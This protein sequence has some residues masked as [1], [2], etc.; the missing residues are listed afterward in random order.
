MY[1]MHALPSTYLGVFLLCQMAG[2]F[3]V[4]QCHLQACNGTASGERSAK[5]HGLPIRLNAGPV[6]GSACV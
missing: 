5:E 3:A 6:S 1:S 2:F 4:L